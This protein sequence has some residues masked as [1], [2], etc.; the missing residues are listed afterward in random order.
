M[1]NNEQKQTKNLFSI[2]LSGCFYIIILAALASMSVRGCKMVG[3]KYEERKAKH[4]M[5][6]DS[7][8]KVKASR[9][10]TIQYK[11]R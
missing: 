4:E 1:E 7:L 3:M 8:N 10:D 9:L 5:V 11:G 6:M 2:P